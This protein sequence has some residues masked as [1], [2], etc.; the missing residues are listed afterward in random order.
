MLKDLGISILFYI[1][2]M[3]TNDDGSMTMESLRLPIGN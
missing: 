2:A 1:F 3:S